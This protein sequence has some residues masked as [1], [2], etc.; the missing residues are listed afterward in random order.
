MVREFGKNLLNQPSEVISKCCHW[1]KYQ[2]VFPRKI[3]VM[4]P[5]FSKN[6]LIQRSEVISQ[7]CHWGKNKLKILVICKSSLVK[8][9]VKM[10][11][12]ELLC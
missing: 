11:I 1:G 8:T 9:L 3:R 2:F 6:I 4:V 5:D 10:F 12:K 7:C